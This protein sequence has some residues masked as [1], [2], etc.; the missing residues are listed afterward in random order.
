[1]VICVMMRIVGSN[2]SHHCPSIIVKESADFSNMTREYRVDLELAK[3][4]NFN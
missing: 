4:L 2:K 3:V 1:M